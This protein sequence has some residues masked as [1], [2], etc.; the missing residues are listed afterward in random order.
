[1]FV[2]GGKRDGS[3]IDQVLRNLTKMAQ[4]DEDQ[5]V[6]SEEDNDD[7]EEEE[8]D[9][10]DFNQDYFAR[11]FEHEKMISDTSRMEF[12]HHLIKTNVHRSSAPVVLDVGTGTGVLACWANK[13]GASRVIAIDHSEISL[14]MAGTLASA[15]QCNNVELMCGH[16]S[17]YGLGKELK[18]KDKVD[19]IVHEQIGDI[20]FD[21]CMVRTIQDLRE[22]VLKTNGKIVPSQFN[23]YIEPV[24]LNDQRHVS[25]MSNLASHGLDF[26]CLQSLVK[27]PEENPD[28][29]HFRSS[30]PSLVDVLLTKP[31]SVWEV[32]L[33]TITTQDMQQQSTL[34]WSKTIIETNRMDALCVYFSCSDSADGADSAKV[35]ITSG[36]FS[37]RCAHWGFRLLRLPHAMVTVGDEINITVDIADEG[38]WEDLNSWRWH[39][40]KTG[41]AVGS[42]NTKG[43]NAGGRGGSGAGSTKRKH[44]EGNS[45]SGTKKKKT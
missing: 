26:S 33:H 1:M 10:A 21:E 29:Y 30:D 2:E 38:C 3:S 44:T 11:I 39:V 17:Q 5:P 31:E 42:S 45:K 27:S 8:E 22:R 12:Y 9:Y 4:P 35:E 36:P 34:Q 32:D 23:L 13:C 7:D 18:E 25:M 37:N 14:E 24:K 6:N 43:D 19:I 16:S 15:N 40:T 41:D 20:L 28:Y